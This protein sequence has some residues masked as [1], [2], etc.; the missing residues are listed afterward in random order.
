MT[1][2]EPMT[3]AF[4]LRKA[5]GPALLAVAGLQAQAP[6]QVRDAAALQIALEKLQVV[7]TVLYVA[8]HPDDENTAAL[9]YFSQG[10]KVRAAYL[11]M[12]RGGGGQNLIG[13][14]QGD[15]LAVLRTQE[16]LAARRLDGAEQFF[17]RAVDF[18]FSKTASETL[19]FWGHESALADVVWTIRKL[20]PDV[21]LTRFSPTT[22]G[23]HG[24]H[25]ASAILALEAF[26]AA[27]DPAR[28]PEQLSLVRPWQARRIL[29]NSFRPQAEREAQAPGA[30]VTVDVGQYDPLLG[31]AYTELAAESRSM[32]RS[33]GF[34]AVAARGGRLEYF[35]LLAGAPLKGDLLEG[36][37]LTWHRVPGGAALGELLSR[38]LAAYQPERPAEALPLL[39]QAKAALDRLEADPWVD[40]KRKDL[41]EAIRCAAGLWVEAIAERQTTTAGEPL[42][43]AATVL[44]RGGLP[45][46]LEG[47]DLGAPRGVGR[48]LPVNQPVT[49][50]FTVTLPPGT[51]VAQ[52]YWLREP[53]TLGREAEAQP[54]FA[55]LPEQ[56]PALMATFRLA[57][58]GVPF[59]LPVPVRYRFRDPV[60]GERYHPVAV[61]PRVMVNLTEAVQIFGDGAAREVAMVVV[62]GKAN[63]AG[64]LRFQVTGG[65]GW[66]VEP[67]E[68]PFSLARSGD[69]VRMT[70][71][72]HPPQAAGSGTLKVEVAMEGETAPAL[73]LARVDYPHLPLQTYFPPATARLVRLDLRRRGRRLGYVMGAGDDLPGVLRPLGYDVDLLSDEALAAADLTGYD[74]IIIGIRAFNT[75]PRMAQLHQRILDYVARGGTEVVQYSVDQGLVTP[76]LGPF[77]FTVS[78]TRVS[79]EEAP[80]TLLA[81]EHPA[82][83]WPNRITPA[84]FEGWV[85]ERGLQFAADWDARYK[86]ILSTHDQGEPPSGGGLLVASHGKGRFVYTGLS[87]FRQLPAGVPGA[88]RLFAN[89]LALG[90]PHE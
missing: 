1:M 18:G 35:D 30:F 65:S 13:S 38:A 40:A 52:P 68:L 53:R 58:A 62:A 80:V 87:F 59:E 51:P 17:T 50:R 70:V 72:L 81:P 11:S 78:R 37:D 31:K 20:R 48:V 76:A 46:T 2:D 32:H 22:G 42:A 21:I 89:L 41:A 26:T 82:L 3:H 19:G 5:L 66:R 7:G 63:A 69:E 55:G 23:T 16:L 71:R 14:E 15:G 44:A 43:V 67:T 88:Y 74:A 90:Q 25:T 49:E 54:A 77:P 64:T 75:R 33:Q 60:L 12:T 45:I 57:A 56:P 28:F 85:Q 4:F 34:G 8:A 29:W 73:G 47:I 10:R 61:E 9:A 24:H 6:L 79:E 39:L 84:D 27:A 86:P 36:V 83:N